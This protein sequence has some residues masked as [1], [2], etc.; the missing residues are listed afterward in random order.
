MKGKNIDKSVRDY[1]SDISLP[2]NDESALY[3][4]IFNKTDAFVSTDSSFIMAARTDKRFKDVVSLACMGE[5]PNGPMVMNPRV[6]K[7]DVEQLVKIFL[8][9]HKDKDFKDFRIYFV[10]AN[11][12]FVRVDADFYT[13][14]IK[15]FQKARK[16]GWIN[17][18]EKWRKQQPQ[19]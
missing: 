15:R 18:F 17:D 10:A 8:G 3:A 11:A 9:A 19:K 1:F 16:A 13:P 14:F 4:L 5:Y 6:D 12:R 7:S 2:K